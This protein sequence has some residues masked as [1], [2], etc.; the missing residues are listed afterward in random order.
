MKM[1]KTEMLLHSITRLL[2]RDA[3]SHIKRLLEKSHPSEIAA[4]VRQLPT[5]DGMAVMLELKDMENEPETFV[6]LEGKFLQAYIEHTDNKAHVAEIMHRLPEDE[7]AALLSDIDDDVAVEILSLTKESTQEEV[8]EILQY[9]EDTCGRNMAVNVFSLNQNMKAKEAIEAIQNSDNIESIF[10]VYIVDDFTRLVGV[11][12]LRQILQVKPSRDIKEIM[13][14]DVVKVNVFD[15]QERAAQLV[16]EYNFVSL[17]VVDDTGHLLGMVTVDD[18]IDYIRDEAQEEVMNMAGVEAEA[19][20]DFSYFRSFLSRIIWFGL[21]FL[22]GILSSEIILYFFPDLPEAILPLCFAPLVLRLGGSAS[23]QIT[24][25]T[26]QAVL[27]VEIEH[28][29]ALRALWGQIFVMTL[30]SILLALWLT[31]YGVLR[32]Q[33]LPVVPLGIGVG[34]VMVTV[35][36][37]LI[38]LIVPIIFEKLRFDSLKASSRFIHF[39]M[40]GFSLLVFFQFLMFWHEH[41]EEVAQ[42]LY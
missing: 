16:E 15:K 13:T 11:V 22:G 40:D 35:F 31:I 21:L 17:P 20:D 7:V 32:F 30:V 29:R 10:Y 41:R 1:S 5:E 14:R 39:L 33:Q 34:L 2:R 8:T 12:S 27:N 42:F 24:T 23:T 26:Q 25:L 36:A 19:I 4:V 6:E 37:M 3:T 18:V 9:G 38:G 28:E